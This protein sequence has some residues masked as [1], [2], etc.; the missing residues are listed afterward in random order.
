MKS[1]TFLERVSAAY[2]AALSKEQK[3]LLPI[4]MGHEC[5]T[6]RSAFPPP[7]RS[8]IRFPPT[9]VLSWVGLIF[10]L[11]LCSWGPDTQ[12]LLLQGAANRQK[13]I[14]HW[15][16]PWPESWLENEKY[17]GQGGNLEETVLLSA[18]GFVCR[19]SFSFTSLCVCV[20]YVYQCT[21]R[22]TH[23]GM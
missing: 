20:C 3:S 17:R 11:R 8:H 21:H 6:Q 2:A 23:E 1:H 18:M 19:V 14:P 15:V 5:H 7:Q 4:G 22:H 12:A 16:I 10:L 13:G 9:P